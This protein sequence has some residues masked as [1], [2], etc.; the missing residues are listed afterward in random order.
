MGTVERVAATELQKELKATRPVVATGCMG[1]VCL[2]R[3][4]HFKGEF[5]D[6]LEGRNW[7]VRDLGTVHAGDECTFSYGFRSKQQVDLAG[8]EHL[9]FQVQILFRRADGTEILRVASARIEIT[10]DRDEAERNAD[11][12]VVATHAAQA[13]AQKAK[14][15]N[16]KE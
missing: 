9:P 1:L 6:E 11:V 8:L 14:K 16:M 3:G 4:L 7:L 15:G 2:H 12:K 10:Q 5:D 13:A